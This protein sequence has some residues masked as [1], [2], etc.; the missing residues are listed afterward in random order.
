MEK[1]ELKAGCLVF[2][3]AI[4]GLTL[5]GWALGWFGL[6]TGRPMAKYSEETRKQVYD[7]SR[8]YE[9]GTNRDI[10]LH[11]RSMRTATT[12]AG[13]KAEAGYIRGIDTTFDG[14]LNSEAQACVSEAQ[15]N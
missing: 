9:Q 13:R 8:Q 12:A 2:G 7:T 11:C 10:L 3:G 6:I 1:G 14:T 15:G 5:L 4:V